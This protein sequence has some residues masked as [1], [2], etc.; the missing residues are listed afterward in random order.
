MLLRSSNSN[1]HKQDFISF[2]PSHLNQKAQS[3]NEA[4]GKTGTPPIG[5]KA[6]GWDLYYTPTF[7]TSED[8]FLGSSELKHVRNWDDNEDDAA[9]KCQMPSLKLAHHPSFPWLGR[10]VMAFYHRISPQVVFST[11][12]L[13]TT[14]TNCIYKFMICFY[15]TSLVFSLLC[16]ETSF[17]QTDTTVF[18]SV[19]R[20]GFFTFKKI[21]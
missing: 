11:A 6:T 18:L 15:S 10:E 20:Q 3:I 9:W 21:Q 14:S 19:F 1:L 8:K 13:S 17:L 12:P 4:W 5:E 7:V 16:S 2:S